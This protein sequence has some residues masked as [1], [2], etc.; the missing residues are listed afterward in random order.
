[1]HISGRHVGL[2]CQDGFFLGARKVDG[3]NSAN[4]DSG[5]R[6]LINRSIEAAVFEN[7]NRMILSEGLA[8]D[9]CA[10]GVVTDLD[11]Q[12]ELSEYD[13]DSDE[14][15]FNV[16][17]TQVDVV[18]PKGYAILNAAEPK[19]VEMAKL[20]DGQVI[21]YGTDPELKAIAEHRSSGDKTVFLRNQVIVLAHGTG[22]VALLPLSVLKP[23]KAEKPEMV[24][25]AVAV[26]WA[27]NIS[28]ELIGAGLRTFES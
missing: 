23:S 5:Q 24:M 18:L 8:Y 19:V 16:V 17:R 15:I 1:L 6:V 25:A 21:F 3:R 27:L 20:C 4:W 14:K 28:P 22:E 11:R 26:A 12:E 9:R 10:V 7:T 2:A 13:I